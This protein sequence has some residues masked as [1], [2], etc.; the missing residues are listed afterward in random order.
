MFSNHWH[1]KQSQ[2]ASK[3]KILLLTSRYRTIFYKNYFKLFFSRQNSSL[4]VQDSY[5]S[6]RGVAAAGNSWL[7]WTYVLILVAEGH[8]LP[9]NKSY[10][11]FI[12]VHRPSPFF[13]SNECTYFLWL[14]I[15]FLSNARV[16]TYRA[17]DRHCY[18]YVD[19]R[20][21]RWIFI[22]P[23]HYEKRWF[24]PCFNY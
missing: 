5:F 3:L 20:S 15:S 1:Q 12:F 22:H 14:E 8:D 4:L 21:K 13:L 23:S 6:R 10:K 19:G 2:T 7:D 11:E 16:R 9:V 17:V 18:T 24:C